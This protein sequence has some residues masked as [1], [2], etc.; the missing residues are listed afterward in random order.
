MFVVTRTTFADGA[1]GS[2]RSVNT[3]RRFA[4]GVPETR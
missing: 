1:T 2:P 4:N 3:K